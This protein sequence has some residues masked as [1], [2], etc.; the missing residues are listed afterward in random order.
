MECRMA[1]AAR[2]IAGLRWGGVGRA[3]ETYGAAA[4]V[5]YPTMPRTRWG[6]PHSIAR[7]HGPDIRAPKESRQR[8]HILREPVST[9]GAGREGIPNTAP[10][11]ECS[12]PRRVCACVR[13]APPPTVLCG[14]RGPRT[15]S[16]RIAPSRRTPGTEPGPVGKRCSPYGPGAGSLLRNSRVQR[17]VRWGDA[18]WHGSAMTCSGREVTAYGG[19]DRAGPRSGPVASA[20]N[21]RSRGRPQSAK[22]RGLPGISGAASGAQGCR[23]A[24]QRSSGG[25]G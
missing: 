7:S 11:G 20:G 21:R 25:F 24:A 13:S 12:L 4:R 23:G 9:S 15:G 17:L 10:W 1:R 16:A 2:S 3:R 6:Q 5:C 22:S 8:I 19:G 18:G 14:P